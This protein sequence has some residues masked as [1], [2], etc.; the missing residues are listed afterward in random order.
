MQVSILGLG[1][2][3]MCSGRAE[4][5]LVWKWNSSF[6]VLSRLGTRPKATVCQER[7]ELNIPEFF[8]N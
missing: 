3:E 1:G 7:M 6:C 4:T 5:L 2:G 8:S